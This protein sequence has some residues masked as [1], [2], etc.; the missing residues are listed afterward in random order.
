LC[1]P[2]KFARL[3]EAIR[4]RCNSPARREAGGQAFKIVLEGG[5][6]I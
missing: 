3:A 5:E 2:G 6:K 1:N 4:G